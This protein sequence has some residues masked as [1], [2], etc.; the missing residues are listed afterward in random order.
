METSA[1]WVSMPIIRNFVFAVSKNKEQMEKICRFASIPLNDLENAEAK[2]SLAQNCAVMDAGLELTKDEFLGL[3]IGEITSPTVLGVVG[4]LMQ[5]SKDVLEAMMNIQRFTETFTTQYN[6]S[7][8]VKGEEVYYY[9][10]PKEIWDDMSPLTARHSV[11]ISF[12]GALNILRIMTGH[13]FMPLKIMYRYPKLK[14]TDEYERVF[15]CTPLFN[16]KRNCIVF[17]LKDASLPIVGYNKE[18]HETLKKMLEEQLHQENKAAAFTYQVKEI[19]L[20]NYQFSFPLLEEI[21][22][23]MNI[24][25]RTLQRKLQDEGT[26]FRNIED[27][28]KKEIAI[29]FIQNSPLTSEEIGLKLGYTDRSSFQR[30]FKQWTG[31]TP[32]EFKK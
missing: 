15:K 31:K 8:E 23:I 13:A 7:V 5:A 24:T 21:A 30:A 28:I 32:A 6:F 9:C 3:H 26:N 12:A 22:G 20:K 25:A 14:N 27:D 18:L 11:D 19:I 4:H 10:E 2:I 29:N 17:S 1:F 16:Q